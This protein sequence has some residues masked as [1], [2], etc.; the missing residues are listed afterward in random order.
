[1]RQSDAEIKLK[2]FQV[3]ENAF[4]EVTAERFITLIKRELFD[5][6]K[7]QRQLLKDVD[8]NTLS[9]AATKAIRKK[10]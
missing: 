1:M 10:I 3:L 4:G 5:Y 6:T 8:V 2:G 7:W 9:N